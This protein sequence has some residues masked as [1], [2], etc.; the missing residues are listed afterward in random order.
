MVTKYHSFAF[1]PYENWDFL[2]ILISAQ[3]FSDCD[4]GKLML[5]CLKQGQLQIWRE[6]SHT[7]LWKYETSREIK[8]I[9]WFYIL[10]SKIINRKKNVEKVQVLSPFPGAYR[11]KISKALPYQ[12]WKVCNFDIYF[13]QC[14]LHENCIFFWPQAKVT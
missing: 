3:T 11:V 4:F 6:H 8:K 12:P 14:V 2:T 5:I 9:I 13:A 10:E 1:H 7:D